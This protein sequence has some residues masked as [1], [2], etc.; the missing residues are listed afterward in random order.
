MDEKKRLVESCN[1]YIM[2]KCNVNSEGEIE[3]RP[4]EIC[5]CKIPLLELRQKLLDKHLRYMRI[6]NQR[7]KTTEE[8]LEMATAA[9]YHYSSSSDPEAA[10]AELES[11][12]TIRHLAI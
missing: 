3:V 5:G 2:T 9:G 7:V 1:P 4:T 6:S 11:Y 12:Q 10:Y 8:L